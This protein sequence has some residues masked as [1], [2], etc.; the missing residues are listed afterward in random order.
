M[1]DPTP[2]HLRLGA[3]VQITGRLIKDRQ[4]ART[5]SGRLIPGEERVAHIPET[6]PAKVDGYVMGSR[7]LRDYTVIQ[8]P[9]DGRAYTIPPGA[10][11][12]GLRVYLVA[13]TMG[14]RP[15]LC[16]PDQIT[17]YPDP[18]QEPLW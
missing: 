8:E 11:E 14:R 9:D 5:T 2:H 10:K 18:R 6:F 1:T 16:L 13:W 4:D 15:H 3:H 7:I 17:P 12:E